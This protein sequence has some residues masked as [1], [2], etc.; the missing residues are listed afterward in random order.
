M[1]NSPMPDSHKPDW[2]KLDWQ[3][4]LSAENF[5]QAW[6]KVRRNRG[7][8]G[9]DG[10]TVE[11][12]EQDADRKLTTLRRQIETG[13]YQPMPLRSLHIPKKPRPQPGEPPKTEWRGLAVPTVGDRIVPYL[14]LCDRS[15]CKTSPKASDSA[16]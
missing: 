11:A 3:L 4:F 9:L 10:E 15:L 5:W 1:L 2:P 14:P 8:A 12:F 13:T 16:T 6:L 7:C